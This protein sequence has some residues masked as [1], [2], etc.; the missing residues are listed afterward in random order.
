MNASSQFRCVYILLL[1]DDVESHPA[2][3]HLNQRPLYCRGRH[4]H[5]HYVLHA[6][7]DATRIP[8][9]RFMIFLSACFHAYCVAIALQNRNDG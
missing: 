6:A 3:H 4:N 5:L 9:V 8:G 2:A 7:A 1:W